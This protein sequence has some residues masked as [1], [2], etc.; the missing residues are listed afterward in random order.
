MINK[1]TRNILSIGG[2]ML[3]IIYFFLKGIILTALIIGLIP[4]LLIFGVYMSLK[5]FFNIPRLKNKSLLEIIKTSI[6]LGASAGL[7]AVMLVKIFY[8]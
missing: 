4:M 3:V 1:T 5:H 2:L 6:G 7:I 8:K